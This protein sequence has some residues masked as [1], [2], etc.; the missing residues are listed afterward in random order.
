MSPSVLLFPV[1]WQ[2]SQMI[3]LAFIESQKSFGIGATQW[4]ERQGEYVMPGSLCY[5]LLVQILLMGHV[6][7]VLHRL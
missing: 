3:E 6:W 7:D 5:K 2:V 1:N 4:G